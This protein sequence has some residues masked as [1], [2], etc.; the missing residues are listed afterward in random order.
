MDLRRFSV[1]LTMVAIVSFA[2]AH[3]L[4]DLSS[5]EI[6][7][8]VAVIRASKKFPEGVRFP[9]LATK[10]P[11]K[12]AI[13]AGKKVPRLAQATILDSASGKFW[14][15]VVDLDKS[16][17][18][19]STQ[20][21]GSQPPILLEEYE[22]NAQIMRKDPRWVAAIKKRGIENPDDVAIDSWVPGIV[23]PAEKKTGARIMRGVSYYKGKNDNYYG[24]PIEGLIATV[25][26]GQKKVIEILDTGVVPLAKG[27]VELTEQANG[28]LRKTLK[29]VKTQ[30]PDGVSF[31]VE[32]GEVRWEH[33]RFRFSLHP[34]RGLTLYQVGYEEGGKVRSI[35][36]KLGL[37]EMAVPYGDAD[38]TWVFRNAFD[39]GEYGVGRTA[40][41]LDPKTDVLPGAQFFDAVFAEDG[42]T[43]FAVPRAVALYERDAGLLWKH[44]DQSSHKGEGRRGQQLV[45]TFMTTVGNYDYGIEY[46]FNLDGTLEVQALLTGMLQAKGTK[47]TANPCEDGCSHLVEPNVLAPNHQHFFAF[48]ADLD[49]DGPKNAPVE[50]N[51]KAIESTALNPR[52]NAFDAFP[53][54]LKR[55]RLAAR[56]LNLAASRKWKVM[57]QDVKNSLSHPTG[58]LLIPGENALPFLKPMSPVRKRAGFVDHQVWFTRY[59]EAEQGAAGEYPNQLDHVD[60]LTKYISDNESLERQDVVLWYTFGVTHVTRPEEWPIMNVH[61]A[62]FKLIPLNFFSRNPAMDVPAPK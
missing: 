7:K 60:G 56:D 14:E 33:W 17:V 30:R 44:V 35:A 58:Y 52:H 4:D 10:E 38:P 46:I 40:H 22:L 6:G 2:A 16:E 15:A 26:I 12:E 53:T 1:L 47:L 25:D 36:Y 54:I 27:S 18:L 37:A 23:T 61:R 32:D 13:L 3:P 21:K 34:Q 59:K 50:L 19:S 43:T 24:R 5:E 39:L 31:S 49:V 20:M 48:R 51:V 55:E 29:P 41:S 57:N 28:P 9:I 45:L 62:G 42:G 8:T 11:E